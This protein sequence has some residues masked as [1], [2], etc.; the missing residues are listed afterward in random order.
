[1]L[2]GTALLLLLSLLL[3]LLDLHLLVKFL[4]K[5][6]NR[7]LLLVCLEVGCDGTIVNSF[8]EV[9]EARRVKVAIFDVELN[10]EW[11]T[12]CT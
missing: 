1:L 2:G 4:G 11:C 10:G 3:F 6:H 9:E 5:L 7:I 8:Q 12:S